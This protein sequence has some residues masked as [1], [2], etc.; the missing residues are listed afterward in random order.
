MIGP[1]GPR[2]RIA[3]ASFVCGA[4]MLAFACG[5]S[6]A[7][8]PERPTAVRVGAEDVARV[9]SGQLERGPV[10]AGRLTP[11][12]Q[13]VVRSEVGGA[14]TSVRAEPGEQVARNQVL[15]TIDAAALRD[16]LLSARSAASS[17]RA[18]LAVARRE[19]ERMQ[20]LADAGA[21][22]TQ[23][24]ENAQRAVTAAQA[25]VADADARVSSAQEQLSRTTVRSPID[26]A[27]SERPVN[28]GD[29]VQPGAALFTIVDPSSVR[30]EG[31][32][33]AAQFS[34][35]HIG[36][37][38]H[39]E[40][41]GYPDRRF[42]G[43]VTRI[44]PTADPATGQV[45]VTV[46][47]PNTGHDLVAGLFARGRIGTEVA[48][49]PIVPASAVREEDGA[50]QLTVVRDGKAETVPVTVSLRDPL[51]EQVLVE[52]GV[53]PGDLVL[54]GAAQGLTAG[55]PVSIS[56]PEAGATATTGQSSGGR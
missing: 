12:K 43:T 30:L 19:A 54:L 47:L 49:G 34:E 32:I 21:V 8:A 36:D 14:I 52:S 22:A 9:E 15:A 55:T 20:T 23:E 50:T 42:D 46:T 44:N 5:G 27:V 1:P 18:A 17:A 10:V 24:S 56:A 2:L 45:R 39:F 6:T 29:V 41:T 3:G 31:A 7:P 11:E 25:Q 13:A 4:A 33:P 53:E 38:V 37:P 35:V 51:T 48:R 40:V 26:G 16:Q 28:A